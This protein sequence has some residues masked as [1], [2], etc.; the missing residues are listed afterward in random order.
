MMKLNF[1]DE[2]LDGVEIVWKRLGEVTTIKTGQ[3]V[4]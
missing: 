1:I 4:S 2:L 3:S